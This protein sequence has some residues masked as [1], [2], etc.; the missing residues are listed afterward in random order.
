MRMSREELMET[1]AKMVALGGGA[2]AA[3]RAVGFDLGLEKE[4][5]EF[6]KY[7]FELE[8]KAREAEL[9]L[10]GEKLA[11]DAELQVALQGEKL[12]KEAELQLALQKE[13]LEAEKSR[14]EDERRLKETEMQHQDARAREELRRQDSAAARIKKF[15]DAIRNSMSQQ[16]NDPIETVAFFRNA[17]VLFDK[18]DV[19]TDLRGILIRPFLN[20]KSKS[21][22]SR[23]DDQKAADYDELKK[24]V[25]VENQLTPATYREKFSSLRKDDS[26]TYVMFTSR[27]RGLL[28]SYVESRAVKSLQDL[29]ELILCDRIK[30]VVG[31]ECLKYILTLDAAEKDGWVR[32]KKL[33][34]AIDT[35]RANYVGDKPRRG[36]LGTATQSGPQSSTNVNNKFRFQSPRQPSS[37]PGQTH[38]VT[39]HEEAKPQNV[40]A[41]YICQSKT[42]LRYQCPQY[43]AAGTEGSKATS[44]TPT[45]KVAKCTV[46]NKASV[47][48]A[49]ELAQPQPVV[50]NES[51]QARRVVDE[52]LLA[53]KSAVSGIVVTP[54]VQLD[55]CEISKLH[56]IT[57]GVASTNHSRYINVVALEDGGAQL[58]VANRSVIAKLDDVS[59][60]G[61]VKIG[62]ALGDSVTCDLVRLNVCPVNEDGSANIKHTVTITCAVSDIAN[63]ELLIPADIVKRLNNNTAVDDD[64]ESY[65]SDDI[66]CDENDNDDDEHYDIDNDSDCNVQDD[67]DEFVHV[68]VVTRSGRDT[69]SAAANVAAAAAAAASR[70]RPIVCQSSRAP[71][72][73]NN[74]IH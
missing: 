34:E 38:T 54:C 30:D 25:L 64:N 12:A 50:V 40:R 27:L 66:D 26:E 37:N 5:L 15:G 21:F 65:C 14:W 7:K 53:C 49:A 17:E 71:D 11:K 43:K 59:V 10:Q 31:A 8:M 41:C 2:A 69:V 56:Y 1:W 67:A 36:T 22:I 3:P 57:V 73:V 18:L 28:S 23:L 24:L 19:P 20:E 74:R 48:S 63:D 35:Y 55:D 32:S 29:T 39:H 70:P 44:N 52:T 6:E 62:L 51:S 33:A 58:A 68:N 9:A 45:R 42:H 72:T 60:I 13:R 47:H 46:E 4:R 61:S 16:S